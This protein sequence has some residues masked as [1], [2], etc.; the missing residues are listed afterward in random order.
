MAASAETPVGDPGHVDDEAE[1]WS[2]DAQ[3]ARSRILRAALQ[4]FSQKGISGG[5]VDAI[6]RTAKAN[7]Q[8]LYYYFGSKRGLFRAVLTRRRSDGSPWPG[9]R[10]K[11]SVTQRLLAQDELYRGGLEY[12]R[13][14]VW[15]ALEEV[16]ESSEIR[17]RHLDR[18]EEQ[19]RL[20]QESGELSRD[21]DVRQ[22][23]LAELGVA[24]IPY[25]M[26]HIAEIILGAPLSDPKVQAGRKAFLEWLGGRL[27][28]T[29]Q[30][31]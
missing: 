2:V 11:S 27:H 5:R 20:D 23:L 3:D 4:E 25:V 1:G 28:E 29:S 19:M 31:D 14:L 18:Y 13:L 17:D 6:A 16:P 12:V 15:E 22:L 30:S 10:P 26:P 24:I 8:L 7:K 9:P 21:V